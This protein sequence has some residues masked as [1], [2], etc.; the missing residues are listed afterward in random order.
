MMDANQALGVDEA[1]AAMEPLREPARVR[2]GRYVLPEAPGY[3]VEMLPESLDEFE[4]PSGPA[5][6]SA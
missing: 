3:P 1:I 5:W 2:R 4:L 6:S